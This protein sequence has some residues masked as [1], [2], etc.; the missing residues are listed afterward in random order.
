MFINSHWKECCVWQTL[1]K[2]CEECLVLIVQ[3]ERMTTC[4]L[5]IVRHCCLATSAEDCGLRELKTRL[6]RKCFLSLIRGIF[7]H[8]ISLIS[9]SASVSDR[10]QKISTLNIERGMPWLTFPSNF[11]MMNLTPFALCGFRN[12]KFSKECMGSLALF[13][14][15]NC[16]V[17]ESQYHLKCHTQ[18]AKHFT[19]Y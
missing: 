4:H 6:L 14:P 2:V 17:F 1:I 5:F 16:A 9:T 8:N 19:S 11:R 13:Q 10:A 12:S 15:R 18:R 3:S 7:V